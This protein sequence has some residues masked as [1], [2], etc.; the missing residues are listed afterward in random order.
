ADT[1]LTEALNL[2]ITEHL[3]ALPV[4][5]PTNH[6]VGLITEQDLAWRAGLRLKPALLPLLTVEERTSAVAPL[7]GRT[8]REV[9]S[10]EPR[11]VG[12]NT[13]IPQ[14]LITM[15][16]WGYAQIPVVDHD[17]RLAGLLG[18][19]QVLRESV[20]QAQAKPAAGSVRDAQTPTAVRL[21]MQ[22]VTAQVAAS[23]RLNLALAQ[24][25]A[26][27][28]RHLLVVDDGGRL[29]GALDDAS[30]L[31]QLG[32]A[33]RAAFLAA[34]QR[35]QAVPAT[36]LPGDDRPVVGLI[37]AHPSTLGPQLS[38]FDAAQRLLDLGIERLPVVDGDQQLLG[39]IARSG[40]I[41]ALM[42]QS[43]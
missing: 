6:L 8:A 36:A 35:P 21:V 31:R 18:Q 10:A 25:L 13:A 11:S 1:P 3:G 7:A 37:E 28:G 15:I 30:A 9:M 39:I 33:E 38:V 34:L 40:L 20:A 16:E 23:T 32:G 2:L 22:P 43:E 4:A 42:Q 29:V 12:V 26:T 14:A 27:P 5:D 17:G 19:E 24:L 41:R